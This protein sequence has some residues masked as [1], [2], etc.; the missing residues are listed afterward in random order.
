MSLF[1]GS[2]S[3]GALSVDSLTGGYG[4]IPIVHD[5][6]FTVGRGEVVALLGRNGMGKSTL[7]R[8]IFGTAAR[9]HGGVAVG[10]R[11]VSP[12]RPH[13]LAAAGASLMP[14]DRGVFPSLTV[15]QNLE[16]A[17]RRYRPAVDP[18][19]V[20]PLLTERA[21][22]PAGTLSGGQQQQL[23]IARAVLAGS[24]LVGVDE[25]TQ[26][27]QP[28]VVRDVFRMLRRIAES[29]VGV[30]VV[31]QNPDAVAGWCDRVLVM[32]GGRTVLDRPGGEGVADALRE[33]LVVR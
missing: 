11:T 14:E 22:Q 10:G 31:D 29:G 18:R 25:L 20:F 9:M 19:D 21:S 17:R 2:L 5:V 23:G 27:L 1:A 30:L 12:G 32:E 15:A 13:L 8:T 16:L 4:G 3:V 24:V 33:L 6:S 26:G 28:S 7:L